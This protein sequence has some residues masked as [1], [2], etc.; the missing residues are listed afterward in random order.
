MAEIIFFGIYGSATLLAAVGLI[1]GFAATLHWGHRR[2]ESLIPY[3]VYPVFVA[4]AIGTLLSGRNLYLPSELFISGAPKHSIVIWV[5]RLT[6]IFILIVAAERIARRLLLK[7]QKPDIPS[8]LIL[9]FC[10]Y[11]FTNILTSALLGTHPSFS[12]E[13]IYTFLAGLAALML[14]RKDGDTTLTSTR[15][16]LF[17]FLV[18]SALCAAW[19]P[20]L[21]LSREYQGLIPG[22]RIRYAG[23]SSHQNALGP[24]VIVFLL[25]L[26]SMPF[27]SR[28]LNRFAWAIGLLSIF[29]SQSKTSWVAFMLCMSCVGYYKYRERLFSGE[30][31]N[32]LF[33][34]SAGLL[35]GTMFA[36]CI[37]LL[38]ILFGGDIIASKLSAFFSTREGAD[39]LTLTGRDQIWEAATREWRANPMF[40]YGL[41]IW[42]DAHRA[43]IGLVN[44]Y[45][46]HN[47]FFQTLSSNGLVGVFGLAAYSVT[48][49]Y[50]SFKVAKSSQGVSLAILVLMLIRSISEV[51]LTIVSFGTEQLTHLILLMVIA[52]HSIKSSQLPFQATPTRKFALAE[53]R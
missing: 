38:I 8:T 27:Q 23:L 47:Q 9:A 17:A 6:S 51:P 3:I 12:H 16:A 39:L 43:Q 49:I 29:L 50:F 13:N 36:L 41:T 33:N 34:V 42:S 2:E 40:G 11:F 26:W 4:V 22:L 31:R 14:C 35:A 7:G 5:T 1:F 44:A 32:N 18:L 20:E 25:C 45:H 30:N 10:L 53:M 46:A 48:L 37:P 15:N 24:L 19:R 21:V 28:I 52:A